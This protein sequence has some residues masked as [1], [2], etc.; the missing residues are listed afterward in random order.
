MKLFSHPRVTF[1]IFLLIA[2]YFLPLNN[3]DNTV[4]WIEGSTFPNKQVIELGGLN[5]NIFLSLFGR[6]V[7][8]KQP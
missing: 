1:I 2:L 6:M 8:E 5:E 7:S 4:R 3:K